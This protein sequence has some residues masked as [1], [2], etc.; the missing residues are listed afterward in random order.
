M[1]ALEVAFEGLQRGEPARHLRLVEE[2]D[3]P[4][5]VREYTELLGLLPWALDPAEPRPELRQDLLAR[6]AAARP[7]LGERRFDEMTLVQRTAGDELPAVADIRQMTAV[8]RT[9]VFSSQRRVADESLPEPARAEPSRTRG[10]WVPFTLAAMLGL[11]LLGLGYLAGKLAEQAASLDRLHAEL[12]STVRSENSLRTER[13]EL[14]QARS[15]LEMITTVA[16]YTYPLHPTSNSQAKVNGAVW[17]CGRHQ[18]W[19]LNLHGLDPAPAGQEYQLWF[20]TDKGPVPGGTV[21]V[22]SDA[23]AELE[24]PSMPL[25]TEGFVVTLE[26]VG[27]H[28]APEGKPILLADKSVSL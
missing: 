18:Q 22:G 8:D 13:D 14:V 17:V 25:N 6:L 11:C 3:R 4:E 21:E 28:P 23:A 20:L 12:Q 24:A 19:Y 5:L 10:G 9:L 1:G 15:N 7:A 27:F 26:T 16:R 2:D